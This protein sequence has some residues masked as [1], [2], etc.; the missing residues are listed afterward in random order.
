M[1][2]P[3][4][5]LFLSDDHAPWTL[6]C[7]GNSEVYSP[8][9]NMMAENGTV[10]NN[11]FTPGPVCSPGRAC[12]L[13]GRLPSQ[14]GIHDWIS[15]D[16]PECMNRDWLADELTLAQI[17]KENGYHCGLSGK[18]HLGRDT[19]TPRGY[20]WYF[21]FPD[22][23]KPN[24]HIGNCNYVL[25]GDN[26]KINGNRTEITTEYAIDFLNNTKEDSPFFLQI[27]YISTHSP[28]LGQAP[29]LVDFYQEASFNDIKTASPHPCSWN[30]DFPEGHSITPG[31][32][33]IRHQNQYAAVTDIDRNIK[34]ILDNL[35]KS[36]EIENTIIIYTSDHGLS[37]GQNGFWGKGNGTR[38]LNMYDISCRVPLLFFGKS[39][40]EGL[41]VNAC[42]DH[43][44]SFMTICDLCEVVPPLAERPGKSFL[45]LLRE[46]SRE[47]DDTK[48]GEYGDT[49]TIRTSQFKLVMRYPDGPHELFNLLVD[50]EEKNNL[51]AK[52][53]SN[54]V[55][56]ELEKK[57]DYYFKKY[58]DPVK[59]GLNVK[60]LPRHNSPQKNSQRISSEGWRDGIRERT[61]K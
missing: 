36:G 8:S 54:Q 19:H 44:D 59:N 10:F 13:T 17:L 34:K 49:R 60:E 25:N 53:S 9:F 31:E 61:T 35:E 6:P 24:V 58:S 57:L 21:G 14:H 43:L 4:I 18:W 56:E 45:P 2:R 42:V 33:R 1:G 40:K 46:E 5:I 12:L 28:F 23:Q 22:F 26:L 11:A 27:G 16:D 55:V 47:W 29:E 15:M 48:F 7:Y 52:K 41:R 51:F 32:A 3:N 50:P 37:L 39:I 38:P 20:D 30:E